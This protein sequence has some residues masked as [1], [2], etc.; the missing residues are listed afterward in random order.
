MLVP[1]GQR[2]P[3]SAPVAADAGVALRRFAVHGWEAGERT[4]LELLE[5]LEDPAP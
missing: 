5:L 2:L 1:T 3:L 4:T